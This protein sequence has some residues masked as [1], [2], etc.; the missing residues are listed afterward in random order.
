MVE[1]PARAISAQ[2]LD[3]VLFGG[4]DHSLLATFAPGVKLPKQFKPI[5]LVAEASGS[6]AVTLDGET[7]PERGWDSILG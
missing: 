2:A 1:E 4:E 5:G 6:P 7:V 3:W